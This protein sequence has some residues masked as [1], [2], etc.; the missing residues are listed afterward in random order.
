MIVANILAIILLHYHVVKPLQLIW[1]LGNS[2]VS[3]WF[4]EK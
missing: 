3:Y 1:R 4:S 2:D